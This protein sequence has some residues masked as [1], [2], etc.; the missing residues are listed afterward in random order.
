MFDS[1]ILKGIPTNAQLAITLLRIGEA[2]RAPIPPPPRSN[3]PPGSGAIT[4]SS[5]Y[6][7]AELS[8]GLDVS[9]E[10]LHKAIRP[11]TPPHVENPS[12]PEPKQ[13]TGS[14]ILGFFKSTTKTGVN[15]ALGT[16]RLR[17]QIGSEHAKQRIGILPDLSKEVPPMGPIDFPARMHG[18]RG[19]IYISAT[20]VTP[21]V[22]FAFESKTDTVKS[23]LHPDDDEGKAARNEKAREA[24]E[25]G[26]LKPQ[27]SV[28][29]NEIKEIRKLGGLGWKGKLI[30]GWALEKP[31]TDGLEI[32][33]VKGNKYV[34]TAITLREELFNRLV[35]MG[36]QKWEAW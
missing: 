5:E 16:D 6:D 25:G 19:A 33:D 18:K 21:C 7:H 11:S 22:S 9:P 17:A 3:S 29:I 26:K 31:V 15:T 23:M 13:K 14:K 34:C 36:A 12:K 1:T 30:V 10:E 4:P 28:A 32:I 27:W 8:E 24:L 35:S 20:A 2:N